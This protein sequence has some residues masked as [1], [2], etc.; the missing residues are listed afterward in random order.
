MTYSAFDTLAV[1][2]PLPRNPE[3][4]F[5][6]VPIWV[7]PDSDQAGCR[8]AHE[9]AEAIRDRQATGERIVLG[10][11]TGS[12]P[13]GI[14]QE[15]I[16][17][18][19]EEGLSFHNVETFNLDEYYGLSPESP[20]SYDHFMHEQL[21]AHVDI[22]PEN[23]H[24]L[25]GTTSRERMADA[26]QQYEEKIRG[27]GGLDIQILGIGR[28][29][30]IG[31]NE[32]GSTVRSRTRVITLDH[33]TRR[34]NSIYFS[35]PNN[36][37]IQA[38]TMGIGT[39][40]DA[41]RVILLA[42]GEH[43]A[44]VVRRAFEDEPHADLPASFLQHHKN[45]LVV[46]DSAAS[47]HLTRVR[48]PWLTGPLVDLGLEWNDLMVRR[49][50]TWLTQKLGKS[51]L[52]LT[53]LDYNENG[54]QELL[55]Q[56]GRAYDINLKVF[57]EVQKTIT[58]WPAGRPD[59]AGARRV[60]VFSPH[61]DDDVISMGGTLLR[62]AQQGHEVHVAYQ[63]SGSNAVSSQTVLKF[64]RFAAESKNRT[65]AIQESTPNG[66][67][68]RPY[69]ALIR[70][71]E[72]IEAAA[73]CGIPESRLH[74]LDMPFYG[75][76][77]NR[78]SPLSDRDITL[79]R[80]VLELV[81]PHQIYAAGDLA[82]PHG[83]HRLC[84]EAVKRAL[85]PSPGS[86]WIAL[87][88]VWLYRGAWKEWPLEEVDMAVPISPSEVLHKRRTIFQHETQKDQAMFLGEDSRE[89]WQRAE[90]RTKASARAFHV[91]GMVDYEAIETFAR[92]HP[93]HIHL[94]KSSS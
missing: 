16:R 82:D 20:E 74:F 89:F 92:F 87:C 84:L 34:D 52:K 68:L 12:T 80:D 93:E 60:L 11:A 54:L 17:L 15:L 26:C 35:D 55:G 56:F 63:V 21:F 49:A 83:T 77:V 76:D 30:H 32:P 18:H 41:R 9:I 85:R 94:P 6:G 1:L 72:A 61:P 46:L 58:G 48:C 13:I 50:V 40:L 69:K 29:G 78:R 81:Q 27:A 36:M 73:I 31:F 88:E 10:L 53:D 67:S 38:I 8:I 19:R 71:L 23:I 47:A 43:K 57:R 65:Y 24:L 62:L 33:L 42:F 25:D 14:Y 91:F 79:V 28:T 66:D 86:P 37:P 7:A 51:V 70:R 45:A 75:N 3:N 4:R 22:L 39:I 59:K 5:E 90:D 64:L 44:D 2:F